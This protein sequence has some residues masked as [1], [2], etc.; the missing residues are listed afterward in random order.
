MMN[1]LELYD[2]IAGGEDSFTEFK[3][4]VTQRTDFADEMI[5]LANTEGGRILVGVEDDGSIS[6][7]TDVRQTEEAIINIARDNS[8]PALDVTIDSVDADGHIVLVVLVPRRV[9]P[10]YEDNSGRCYIR[11]GSTKRR[12]TPQERARLL[13]L[14]GLVHFDETPVSRTSLNDFDVDAFG[15]YYERIFGQSLPDAEVPLGR[16][17]ENMRFLVEDLNSDKRLSVAGLLLFGKRPQDFMYHARISAVRWAGN[18]VGEDIIDRQEIIGRLSEQIEQAVAFCQRNTR[19]STHIKAARQEDVYQYPPPVLREAVVNAVAHR[20]YSLADA[21]TLLYIFDDRLEI[22]SPGPLPNSVTL[23]NIRTHYSKPR[24]E[25][26]ARV[27]FNLGYVNT[28]GSGV[29]RMIRLM[30]ELDSPLPD[31][32]VSSSQF[33]V[34]LWGQRG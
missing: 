16:M 4:D 3:R 20:D 24:N 11:V 19:L 23:D 2:L 29:P 27:L 15:I 28:L 26:I 31:F 1:K 25:L 22:R 12:A 5:A 33:M 10:P 13:Q 18:E 32:E 30:R 9:G 34:R 21:Q 7:V 17:L 14:A 8:N 6:G